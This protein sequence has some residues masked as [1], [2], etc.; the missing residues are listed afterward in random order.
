MVEGHGEDT[1]DV[2]PVRGPRRLLCTLAALI[3]IEND[4]QY[5]QVVAALLQEPASRLLQALQLIDS[6]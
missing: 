4:L 6:E 3:S 5:E 1:W 2:A